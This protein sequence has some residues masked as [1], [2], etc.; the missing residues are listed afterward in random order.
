MTNWCCPVRRLRLQMNRAPLQQ[1]SEGLRINSRHWTTTR[2]HNR[3][4]GG[5]SGYRSSD[6]LLAHSSSPVNSR[7]SWLR[8][9][10]SYLW[11]RT[12]LAGSVEVRN[13][14]SAVST[15]P[16]ARGGWDGDEGFLWLAH[17]PRVTAT[18]W[19]A[20]PPCNWWG[21]PTSRRLGCSA[22]G[23]GCETIEWA[24]HSSEIVRAGTREEADQWA[25]GVGARARMGCC[26]RMGEVGQIT[27]V[28]A[29]W[30]CSSFLFSFYILFL[31]FSFS[32]SI[33][34]QI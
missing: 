7:E 1:P 29:Q 12:W 3:G 26:A 19:V 8:E 6:F 33:W 30:K 10:Q 22:C 17:G 4:D 16:Y 15:P 34:I 25:L 27:R 2:E 24:P 21:G 18:N 28:L 11:T 23:A 32:N 14:G 5:L 13:R 9:R 20:A 31:F